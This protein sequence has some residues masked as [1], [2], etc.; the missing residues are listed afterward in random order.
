MVTPSQGTTG[1][2]RVLHRLEIHDRI[3]CALCALIVVV[4]LLVIVFNRSSQPTIV[5][6]WRTK[7]FGDN[8]GIEVLTFETNGAYQLDATTGV[9]SKKFALRRH[10]F[11]SY[12]MIRGR[13]T[14]HRI[15]SRLEYLDLRGNVKKKVTL[16]NVGDVAWSNIA[17][18]SGSFVLGQPDGSPPTGDPPRRFERDFGD[19]LPLGT[20]Y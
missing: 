10:E 19:N 6:K 16:S 12:T 17:L 18:N 5:G 11:G 4:M 13:L 8:Y 14:L 15:E 3:G 1:F 2:R 9:V 20:Q 7:W